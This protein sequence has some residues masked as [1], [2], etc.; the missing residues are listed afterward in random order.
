MVRCRDVGA[1]DMMCYL[2][3]PEHYKKVAAMPPSA[4]PAVGAGTLIN[5][6]GGRPADQPAERQ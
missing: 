6:L 2:M 5:E 1:V 3:S 4:Q